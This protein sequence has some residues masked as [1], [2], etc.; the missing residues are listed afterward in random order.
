[1]TMRRNTQA[2]WLAAIGFLAA[3]AGVWIAGYFFRGNSDG[4]SS[5]PPGE[6]R[7]TDM[8]GY[9]RQ[10]AEWRGRV[11][12]VN[13]W[14]T[15]C[16]PCRD[17]IPLLKQLQSRYGKE[18]FQVVGVAID[19]EEAVIA[20]ARD[21]GFN[22]PVLIGDLEGLD[23]MAQYGNRSGALPFNVILDP[24]GEVLYRKIGAF[25]AEELNSVVTK[26]LPRP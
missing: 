12:L 13:F 21:I 14:A 22:Y 7:F 25:H 9:G 5:V 3:V 1:M 19:D 8:E 10:L 24:D 2:I 17:E 16:A 4:L 6:I 20:Y 26:Y 18:A 15:W 23:A 11:V